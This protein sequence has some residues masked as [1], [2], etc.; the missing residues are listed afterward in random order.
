MSS[1]EKQLK[2]SGLIQTFLKQGWPVIEGKPVLLTS[3]L[4]SLMDELGGSFI[5]VM[6]DKLS[7]DFTFDTAFSIDFETRQQIVAQPDS[8]I[9]AS[10][11]VEPTS[12]LNE[13]F[14][15]V[16]HGSLNPEH[17]SPMLRVILGG[18]FG[19]TSLDD[20]GFAG[21]WQQVSDIAHA[22]TQDGLFDRYNAI[23]NAVRQRQSAVNETASAL[24]GLPDSHTSRELKVIA[25]TEPLTLDRW[26]QR[27][28]QI[29][30]T[31]RREYHAQ[32][33]K[34]GGQVRN[35]FFKAGAISTRQMP[36]DLLM[37]TA[38]DPGRRCYPLA[39]LTAS[40]LAQGESAERA[41]IG[42][43]ANAGKTPDDADSRALLLA[44]DELHQTP[45]TDHGTAHGLHGVE[46]VVQMLQAKTAPAVMLLD[47][48]NHALLVAKVMQGDTPVFRF[49]DPNFAIFGF[50][51][52]PELTLGMALYLSAGK[53]AMARL[54]GLDDIAKAQFNVTE[55]NTTKIADTVLS[56]NLRLDS[57]LKNQA[58]SDVQG[59]SVWEKQALGRTRSLSENARMGSSLAQLDAR[60]WTQEFAQATDLLRAE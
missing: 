10:H 37:K 60:Y 15:H 41:L 6:K 7:G 47:T 45:V 19:A 39:L 18:I 14:T 20:A 23:E 54:Y 21:V 30:R 8:Q 51:G 56:S 33:L 57:F 35:L 55:L 40:A 1:R 28:E 5:R 13:L 46:G 9:P 22:T 34:R 17:L 12:N 43:V 48:G 58:I 42:R 50:A 44:L 26:R 24:G 59:V 27:V 25:L 32:I 31:A 53:S 52:A 38:G 11:G 29:N 36:Q 49:Y 4:Q 3:V 2:K 16:A